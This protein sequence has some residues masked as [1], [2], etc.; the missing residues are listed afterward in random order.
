MK[1]NL[2]E[3]K[4]PINILK[5]IN[6]CLDSNRRK[7]VLFVFFLSVFSSLSESISIALLV[8]FVSFFI[9]PET[10]LFNEYFKSVLVFFNL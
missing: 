1:S 5:R 3:K 8:P 4:S 9:N 10:Y 7:K 2:E 6:K